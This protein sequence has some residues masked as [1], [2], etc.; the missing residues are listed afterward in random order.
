[1]AR[2]GTPHSLSN[3]RSKAELDLDETRM[4][5]FHRGSRKSFKKKENGTQLS[6]S[7]IEKN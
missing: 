3:Y 5:G 6:G 1:M 7:K 2:S 4:H